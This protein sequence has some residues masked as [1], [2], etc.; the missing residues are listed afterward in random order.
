MQDLRAALMKMSSGKGFRA[1]VKKR[2]VDH[3]PLSGDKLQELI[4]RTMKTPKAIAKKARAA[5][6]KK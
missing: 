6:R 1:E 4:A 2:K 5:L 3:Q